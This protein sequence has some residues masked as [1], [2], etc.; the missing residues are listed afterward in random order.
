M[1]P[2]TLYRQPLVCTGTHFH[3][4]RSDGCVACSCSDDTLTARPVQPEH[5]HEEV[6]RHDHYHQTRDYCTVRNAILSQLIAFEGDFFSQTVPRKAFRK[7]HRGI[8]P[9]PF[10]AHLIKPLRES[11]ERAHYLCR[12]HGWPLP[13]YTSHSSIFAVW[14]NLAL[15]L[16]AYPAMV[17]SGVVAYQVR[18]QR[19]KLVN[20]PV[21]QRGVAIVRGGRA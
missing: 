6:D 12:Q 1:F 16:G 10:P 20:H 17:R 18:E 5:A 4:P 9:D 14:Y 11:L 19:T 21:V 2:R 15:H 8:I 13:C 7:D 3:L